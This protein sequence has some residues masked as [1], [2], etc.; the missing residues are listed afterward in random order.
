MEAIG[1][2]YMM[3]L[4]ILAIALA[5]AWIMVPFAIIGMKPLLRLLIQETRT[6]NALLRE[7]LGENKK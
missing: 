2:F 3:L 6:T 4:V 5:I 7:R 1:A